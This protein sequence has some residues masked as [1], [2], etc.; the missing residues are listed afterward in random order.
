MYELQVS[1]IIWNT[2]P[3]KILKNKS[4]SELVK[5][6]RSEADGEKIC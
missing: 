6:T 3:E 2:W 5:L 1:K 4:N